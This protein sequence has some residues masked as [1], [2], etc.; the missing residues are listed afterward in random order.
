MVFPGKRYQ[1]RGTFFSFSLFFFFPSSFCFFLLLL[2][3]WFFFFCTWSTGR[4]KEERLNRNRKKWAA[5][6]HTHTPQH[7]S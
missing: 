6:P 5:P 1:N 2:L 3:L 7:F 4:N